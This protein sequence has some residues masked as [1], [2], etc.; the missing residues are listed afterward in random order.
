MLVQGPLVRA[1]GLVAADDQAS[2]PVGPPGAAEAA[3]HLITHA[4]RA[5][6]LALFAMVVGPQEP[7]AREPPF[8]ARIGQTVVPAGVWCEVSRR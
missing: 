1:E 4:H 6:P 8:L 7:V 2:T 3:R 5:E